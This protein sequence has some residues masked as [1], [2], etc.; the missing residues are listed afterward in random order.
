MKPRAVVFDDEIVFWHKKIF[1]ITIITCNGTSK[2]QAQTTNDETGLK[3][4][5]RG[6]AGKR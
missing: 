5:V 3:N 1:R 2:R 6:L 4:F